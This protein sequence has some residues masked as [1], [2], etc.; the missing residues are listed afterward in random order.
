MMNDLVYFR[1]SNFDLDQNEVHLAAQSL[2]T[3]LACAVDVGRRP[4]ALGLHPAIQLNPLTVC[5][6]LSDG[7]AEFI[8]RSPIEIHWRI[9]RMDT[10]IQRLL[11]FVHMNQVTSEL[12]VT[13]ALEKI[14]SDFN[15]LDVAVNCAG[16]GIAFLT[17]NFNKNKAHR[18]ED[19]QR[20]SSP[21][22]TKYS[23]RNTICDS[24]IQTGSCVATGR[25]DTSDTIEHGVE[26]GLH[27]GKSRPK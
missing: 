4:Q 8:H 10:R 24:F 20:V 25:T 14:K 19:F 16:V 21:K 1:L 26:L 3:R 5:H 12:D 15:R 6:I 7:A 23:I 9:L 2:M 22:P 11:T 13:A 17:Y 18:L 27:W